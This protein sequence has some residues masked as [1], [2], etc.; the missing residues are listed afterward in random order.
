MEWLA[1][2]I[3]SSLHESNFACYNCTSNITICGR[4]VE[5]GYPR[6]RLRWKP[7]H[8]YMTDPHVHHACSRCFGMHK[9]LFR[10]CE[11]KPAD[12]CLAGN[13][14]RL[15]SASCTSCRT[16]GWCT[17]CFEAENLL[18]SSSFVVGTELH[19]L[20]IHKNVN[21]L[22]NSVTW[23]T[24]TNKKVCYRW[25]HSAPRVKRETRILPWGVGAD[26]VP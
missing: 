13:V 9:Q 11:L 21:N 10:G 1:G 14:H 20:V 3:T 4:T 25:L 22:P 12:A 19:C 18:W 2:K 16:C 7:P 17:Y 23:R 5:E 6:V 26:T 24:E 8:K 15:F